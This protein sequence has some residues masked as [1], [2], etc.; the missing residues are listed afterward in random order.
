MD[1]VRTWNKELDTRVQERTAECKAA[2]QEIGLLYVELQEKERMRRDLLHRI[3][4]VQ[5]D[6]RKRISRELHD[7]TCQVLLTLAMGLENI[8]E[9][10][11]ERTPPS[12]VLPQ[13]EA[14]RS[15]AK[16]GRDGVNRLIFDLRPMMLDHLG[17]L[18]AL[19]WYAEVRLSDSDLRFTVQEIGTIGRL[20]PV[21]ET[22]L[23]RVGQEA[24]NN[25]AQHSRAQHA[26]LTLE[27]SDGHVAMSVSDDGAG[28]SPTAPNT[29]N[30]HGLGLVGM[31]ER[32]LG[33]GG[34]FHI[35]S[36]PGR[37][38]KIRISVPRNGNGS[39]VKGEKKDGQDSCFDCG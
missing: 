34:E 2:A 25:V 29:T 8:G 16:T 3:L 37:G 22:T 13:L 24:I 20:P 9:M 18:S 33:V 10:V 31:E 35:E 14:L 15:L 7:E 23:F 32:I 17:L 21:L 28:F 30:K 36:T 1:E 38:T 11:E 19:R 39:H 4:S 26:N 6:E 27:C 12:L 5:E